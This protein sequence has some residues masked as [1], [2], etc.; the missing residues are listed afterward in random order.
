MLRVD[1]C[2]PTTNRPGG[3]AAQQYKKRVN[4]QCWNRC[5]DTYSCSPQFVAALRLANF[6]SF[7]RSKQRVLNKQLALTHPLL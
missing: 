7:Q 2:Q 5:D 4:A 3:G 6:L 1:T